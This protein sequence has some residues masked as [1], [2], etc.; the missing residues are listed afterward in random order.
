MVAL[1]QLNLFGQPLNKNERIELVKLALSKHK[2]KSYKKC[3]CNNCK[4]QTGNNA[5]NYF[6]LDC[7]LD[8]YVNNSLITDF[9]KI[10]VVAK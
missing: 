8:F 2:R 5:R 10:E 4:E 3:T 9:T 6:C 7:L 1:N